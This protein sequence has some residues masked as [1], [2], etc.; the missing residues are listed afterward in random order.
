MRP[1]LLLS[2]GGRRVPTGTSGSERGDTK[3][4]P[5]GKPTAGTQI[6]ALGLTVPMARSVPWGECVVG[7]PGREQDFP[8]GNLFFP[9]GKEDINRSWT[10]L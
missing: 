5:L 7:K 6:S 1:A 10:M 2:W 8:W 4:P 9:G 3:Q